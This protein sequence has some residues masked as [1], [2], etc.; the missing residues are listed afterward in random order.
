[1][2]PLFSKL[3]SFG[4]IFAEA[5]A[6]LALWNQRSTKFFVILWSTMHILICVLMGPNYFQNMNC[7]LW[8]LATDRPKLNKPT[9]RWLAPTL[10]FLLSCVLAQVQYWPIT[11]VYMYSPYFNMERGIYANHPESDYLSRQGME[12]LAA[13]FNEHPSVPD[14]MEFPGN[15]M[16]LYLDGT[17]K[18][19]KSLGTCSHKKLTHTRYRD[20]ML[21]GFTEEATIELLR[22]LQ[23]SACLKYPKREKVN[24]K[25][26]LAWEYKNFTTDL[27]AIDFQCP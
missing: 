12:R 4:A 27:G 14:L 9:L 15:H 3:C 6:P 8:L 19:V 10:L 25:L 5:G 13:G 22:K 24:R 20:V 21:A 23:P 1:M 11:N 2:S 17:D 7:F 26:K 18:K 16:V